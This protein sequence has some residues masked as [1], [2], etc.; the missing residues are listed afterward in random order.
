[1]TPEEFGKEQDRLYRRRLRGICASWPADESISVVN[2][3]LIKLLDEAEELNLLKL[4]SE[5]GNHGRGG[6]KP[7]EVWKPDGRDTTCWT[8]DI[9]FIDSRPGV[10]GGRVQIHADTEAEAVALRSRVMM[11]LAVVRRTYRYMRLASEYRLRAMRL[12]KS[13]RDLE[14]IIDT[15]HTGEWFEAVRLEAAHQIKRWGIDHDK[16]KDPADWFWLLGY[17][18]GKALASALAGDTEKAKHHIITSAAALLNWFRRI[19][20]DSTAM[21]PGKGKV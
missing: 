12:G 20:G 5:N 16:G 1:M 21:R 4:A 10:W 18:G 7:G 17:L 19:T 2:E 3:E 13:Y 8:A 6:W 14:S 11:S 15:P 9:D